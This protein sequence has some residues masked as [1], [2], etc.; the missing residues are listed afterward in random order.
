MI[1]VALTYDLMPGIDQ[2]AYFKFLKKAIVLIFQQRGILE[3]RAKRS[4]SGPPDIMIVLD[5]G[6][7][8]DWNKFE[9]TKEWSSLTE[10]LKKSFVLNMKYQVWGPSPIAPDP[11]R[12]SKS[13]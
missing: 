1:E 4:L 5:W 10:E 8:A 9:A 6:A 3:I 12:P 2:D 7:A 13:A 11:L